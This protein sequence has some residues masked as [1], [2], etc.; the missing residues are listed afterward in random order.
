VIPRPDALCSA[1]PYRSQGGVFGFDVHS[2]LAFDTLREPSGGDPLE[3]VARRLNSRPA[4]HQLVVEFDEPGLRARIYHDGATYRLWVG[5]VGWF[6]IDPRIPR[7]LAPPGAPS[8]EREEVLW[9]LPALLCF[10]ARGDSSLHAAAIEVDGEAILLV[11]PQA[12]GKS[13]LAAA[14]GRRGYRILSED[15]TCIRLAPCPSVIPGPAGLRLRTDIVPHLEVPFGRTLRGRADRTSFALGGRGGCRPVPIRAVLLLRSSEDGI[16]LEAVEPRRSLPDLWGSSFWVTDAHKRR[17]FEC[18]AG[19]A[20][21]LPIL[22]LHRPLRIDALDQTVDHVLSQIYGDRREPP[23]GDGQAA[24]RSA[25]GSPSANGFRAEIE[26]ILSARARTS[27]NIVYQRVGN[28]TVMLDLKSG[29]HYALN[30][31]AGRMLETLERS[32]TVAEAAQTLAMEY[33]RSVDEMTRDIYE[34]CRELRG[35]GLLEL[36]ELAGREGQNLDEGTIRGS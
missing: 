29:S 4:E 10:L 30:P 36:A 18:I 15:L 2:H 5:G 28:D 6:E 27:T 22:N 25:G 16:S 20:N 19:L 24:P 1:D 17:C 13:T 9:G 12:H 14:F 21:E 11:A 33:D 35:R 31:T 7:V 34:L 26:S 8:V 3:I 23:A 32:P